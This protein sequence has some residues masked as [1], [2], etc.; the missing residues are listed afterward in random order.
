MNAGFYIRL[1]LAALFWLVGCAPL[2]PHPMRRALIVGINKYAVNPATDR[3]GNL[4][5]AVN[6][7][8]AIAEVLKLRHG[9][10]AR[11]I[12]L[13]LDGKATR[14]GILKAIQEHLIDPARPGQISLFFYA[15]HGSWQPSQSTFELDGRDETLVPADTNHGVADI[16]DKE[17]A[18]LFNRVLDRGA[19]F[20]ALVD[21][22]HSGSIARGLPGFA[23]GRAVPPGPPGASPPPLIG[24]PPE[25]RGA[26]I[27]SAAQDR[28]I[29]QER[30]IQGKHRGLFSSSLQQVLATALP[31]ESA[32]Q[33][34]ARTRALMQQRGSDQEPVL[35]GS[36][37]RRRQTLWG[38]PASPRA[39]IAGIAVSEVHLDHVILQ[40]GY[41][42]GL[43][44]LAELRRQDSSPPVR[45]RVTAVLGPSRSRAELLQG[46]LRRVRSGDLFVL[47]RYG[48]TE[49]GRLRVFLDEAAPDLASLR[50]LAR[51]LTGARQDPGA[52]TTDPTEQ[53]P[54]HTLGFEKGGWVLR[55][56]E[57]RVVQSFG[58]NPRAAQVLSVL[59]TVPGWR[60]FLRLPV[61][62]ELRRRI[63]R[64]AERLQLPVLWVREEKEADYLLVGRWNGSQQDGQ[65]EYAW[66]HPQA[67]A[68]DLLSPHWLPARSRWLNS[69]DDAFASLTL[70]AALPLSKLKYWHTLKAPRK[71]P[72]APM[73]MPMPTMPMEDPFPYKLALRNLKSGHLHSAEDPLRAEE[74]YQLL[75]LAK[76]PARRVQ[77]RY[78]Y[79]FNLDNEG[80]G[81]LLFPPATAGNVENLLPPQSAG[82]APQELALGEPLHIEAPYGR[83]SFFLLTS[84][85]AIPHPDQVF[86]FSGVRGVLH[87][88]PTNW[89]IER[90]IT[91]S[92]AP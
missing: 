24:P 47:E 43:G 57:S 74:D 20:T 53:V 22:C 8:L 11:D 76:S 36:K 83:E 30:Y 2:A 32:E 54:T 80:R 1:L 66:I 44:P 27:I 55:D 38:A 39:G 65:I 59:G 78:V 49:P 17:L 46:D 89:S 48:V 56:K 33:L 81:A 72:G 51:E 45:L 9:F 64:S 10:A 62:D 42:V 73:P 67:Q 25:E 31:G 4:D 14:D 79:L 85:T 5:G 82:P 6:D 7:A 41:D 70:S 35:A 52:W 29:A 16:R 75:L 21:S 91:H 61:A 69:Q 77:P 68:E 86:S 60:L 18:L 71:S 40:A 28:Q 23:R 3:A 12:R 88:L 13:L 19:L 15:G 90:L 84:E 34:F 37:E 63:E 58:G 92:Q 50:A 87:E 26:L